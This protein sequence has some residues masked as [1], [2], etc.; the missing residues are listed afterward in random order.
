MDVIQNRVF[1]G[2]GSPTYREIPR[3]ARDDT[4]SRKSLSRIPILMQQRY[5]TVYKCDSIPHQ[6]D[7]DSFSKFF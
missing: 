6:I 2:E 4:A 1:C 5:L 3:Y 7:I